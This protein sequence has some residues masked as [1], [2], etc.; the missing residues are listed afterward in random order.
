MYTGGCLC[1]AV[2]YEARGVARYVCYCHCESCRRAAGAALVP[3]AT[4]ER[5]QLRITHGTLAG[6]PS[7]AGVLR[8]FC[9]ACGTSLTYQSEAR[10]ADVDIAVASLDE[11]AALAPRMHLWVQD[12]L[13]WLP[14]SDG[15]PQYPAG[16]GD[17]DG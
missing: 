13:P 6:Y 3:W 15:L 8:G 2:R 11:P 7:S 10:A 9:S 17:E 12:K 14:I 5:A 1:G 16:L 4:F